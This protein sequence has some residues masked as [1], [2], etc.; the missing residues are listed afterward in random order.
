MMKRSKRSESTT[1]SSLKSPQHLLSTSSRHQP[2][3]L[4][5]WGKLPLLPQLPQ[6]NRIIPSSGNRNH[7]RSLLL[8]RMPTK[9]P[10]QN[11]HRKKDGGKLKIMKIPLML[12]IKVAV[13]AT[14]NAGKITTRVAKDT[15]ILVQSVLLFKR[16]ILALISV[17]TTRKKTP[18]I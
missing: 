18:S 14:E 1:V 10:N 12:L 3:K 15:R 13:G 8:R 6:Q 7:K 5:H 4:K 16:L 9:R 2:N 17:N 11:L